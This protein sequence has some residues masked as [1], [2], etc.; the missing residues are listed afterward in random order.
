MTLNSSCIQLSTRESLMIHV[1]GR[2]CWT[3]CSL[4]CLLA[5]ASA[6]HF[7]WTPLMWIPFARIAF[8]GSWITFPLPA[9]LPPL[10]ACCCV[11]CSCCLSSLGWGFCRRR[12]AA[13]GCACVCFWAGASLYVCSRAV[14]C[15]LCGWA[16]PPTVLPRS[17]CRGC[18]PLGVGHGP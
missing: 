10:S 15:F 7:M 2:S 1:S 9:G 18:S 16:L 3:S 13:C 12:R 17:G 5:P 8:P 14:A 11:H 4:R 6:C